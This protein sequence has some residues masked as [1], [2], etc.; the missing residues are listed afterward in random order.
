[1][2]I[3]DYKIVT[4]DST[5]TLEKKVCELIKT[6]WQPFGNLTITEVNGN[7]VMSQPMVR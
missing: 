7:F 2:Q 6:G 1:M 5:P 4:A 3:S